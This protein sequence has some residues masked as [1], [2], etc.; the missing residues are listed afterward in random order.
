VRDPS[1]LFSPVIWPD[2][3]DCS[4]VRNAPCTRRSSS[5][6]RASTWGATHDDPL[7]RRGARP[8]KRGHVGRRWS[9]QRSRL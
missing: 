5:S 2:N 8:S 4:A 9:Q 6:W 3:L 7:Y 1:A